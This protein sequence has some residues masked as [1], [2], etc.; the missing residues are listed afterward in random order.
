VPTRWMP[1]LVVAA[2]P[3]VAWIL[4]QSKEAA[5]KSAAAACDKEGLG[6]LAPQKLVGSYLATH[7][8]WRIGYLTLRGDGKFFDEHNKAR[9]T[10]VLIGA[11][12]TLNWDG[13]PPAR[14]HPHHRGRIWCDAK[15]EFVMVRDLIG[16]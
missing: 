2:V 12:L 3:V 10:W 1:A 5:S 8:Q 13:Y 7:V 15:D 11:E 4:P 14:L 16:D 6:D 9:G